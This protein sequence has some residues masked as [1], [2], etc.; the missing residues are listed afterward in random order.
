MPNWCSNDIDIMGASDNMEEFQAFLVKAGLD[1]E[2]ARDKATAYGTD[3]SHELFNRLVPMPE[4]LR[5]TTAMATDESEFMQA[6]HGNQDIDY[7]DWYTWSLAHWGTKWDV[8]LRHADLT[9]NVLALSYDTAWSPAN[10]V[11]E[12][13]TKEFPSLLIKVKY[14]EE[15]MN[16][17]GET[18]YTEGEC[19]KDICLEIT[20]QMYKD[21]GAT[22]DEDG[23]VDWDEDQDYNLYELFDGEGLSKYEDKED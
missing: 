18:W 6:L 10:H 11:W 3:T 14:V 12:Y 16:F 13:I 23:A 17:I 7:K 9:D 22:L 20:S 1:T 21:A 19:I 4:H 15:G 2:D 5:G 8:D